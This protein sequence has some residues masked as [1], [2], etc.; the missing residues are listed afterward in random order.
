MSR[1]F[2]IAN[3]VILV[4]AMAFVIIGIREREWL[5]VVVAAAF[6]IGAALGFR[7]T[8]SGTTENTDDDRLLSVKAAAVCGSVFGVAVGFAARVG[9]E[10]TA[11]VWLFSILLNGLGWALVFTMVAWGSN[12]LAGRES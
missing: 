12:A 6:A 1:F 11:L 9:E 10:P 4:V 8:F 2:T 5:V 7:T 3:A